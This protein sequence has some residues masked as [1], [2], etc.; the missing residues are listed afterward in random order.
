[1]ITHGQPAIHWLRDPNGNLCL[2]LENIWIDFAASVDAFIADLRTDRQRGALVIARF[3]KER[4]TVK[5]FVANRADLAAGATVMDQLA[6]FGSSITV[7]S[8]RSVT[9][10]GP[11]DRV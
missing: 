2:N 3:R 5:P 1:V 7:A 11:P 10:E 6:S 4:W 9:G 8:A